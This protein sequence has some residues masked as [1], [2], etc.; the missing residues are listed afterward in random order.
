MVL[1]S[2]TSCA[3]SPIACSSIGTRA[4][5]LPSATSRRLFATELRGVRMRR[6]RRTATYSAIPNAMRMVEP[7]QIISTLEG[8]QL[9]EMLPG[10]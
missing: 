3:V 1:K 7:T 8:I 6:E 4:S 2:R 9:S 5:S 10:R